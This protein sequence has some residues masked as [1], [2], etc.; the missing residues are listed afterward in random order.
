MTT[1]QLLSGLGL[2][3]LMTLPLGAA[4]AS[5]PYRLTAEPERP[6]AGE[7]FT[8]VLEIDGLSGAALGQVKASPGFDLGVSLARPFIGRDGSARGSR[9][10]LEFKV[11][12]QGP[13]TIQRLEVKGNEGNLV[14]GPLSFQ[15]RAPVSPGP[16]QAQAARN[17][18]WAWIAPDKVYRYSSFALGL[19]LLAGG[20]PVPPSALAIFPPPEGGS[21]EALPGT[22]LS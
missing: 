17:R 15:A 5:F 13:W 12:G 10:S 18:A 8:I 11:S 6:L 2:A 4:P 21:L 1:R 19:E 9:L 22:A 3:V 14:L 20:D 7:S 16:G